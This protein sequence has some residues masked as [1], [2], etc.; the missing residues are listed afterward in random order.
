MIHKFFVAC[1]RTREGKRSAALMCLAAWACNGE[2]AP[3]DRAA[4]LPPDY[5][6]KIAAT[7]P[8]GSISL[9]VS[10]VRQFWT[11]VDLL[12]KDTE[13]EPAVW[14]SLF[15]TPG[16]LALTASEFTP[17]FFQENFR[18]A[19]KPSRRHALVRELEDGRAARYLRHYR[20]VLERRAQ[21]VAFTA[22]LP[23]SD[24]LGEPSRRAAEWLPP[25]LPHD[26]V[27]VALVVF[28]MD[29]RGY[30]PI[31]LDVLA[32]KDMDLAAFLAHESH[33][34]YRNRSTPIDW[35]RVAPE[36]EAVLWT[37]YQVQGEGIADMIDK[38]PWL[39]G[40]VPVPAPRQ[41]YAQRY[42]DALAG[43]PRKLKQIDSLLALLAAL[44][45]GETHT[46]AAFR[47]AIG[48]QLSEAV[49]MSGH[50]TGYFMASVILEELGQERLR[51]NVGNP[52]AFFRTYD[53][54]ARKTRGLPMLSD[55]ALRTLADLEE[56][57]IQEA[58]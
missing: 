58:Q 2:A 27:P 10:G 16:Y 55:G 31:V 35:E 34:W 6:E 51:A 7:S 33:H 22:E 43:T 3:R 25:P 41:G 30:D 23:D 20:Q 8:S 13:P 45:A 21:L 47:T 15:T 1:G 52:L 26:L 17:S 5:I 49:P 50:P 40:E 57:Y 11:I 53:E 24:K 19:Y 54:A 29:G 36:D 32:A 42:R 18:L 38:R 44:P 48:D 14:D 4:D 39:E 28:D 46:L 37:L 56:R 12:V 9:D